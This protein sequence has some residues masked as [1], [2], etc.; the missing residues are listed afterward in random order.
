MFTYS[1]IRCIRR[2]HVIVV[3]WTSKK[4]T[5]KREELL[6][7][8]QN[9]LFFFALSLLTSSYLLK[10][11]LAQSEHLEQYPGIVDRVYRWPAN[12]QGLPPWVQSLWTKS[13]IFPTPWGNKFLTISTNAPGLPW[14]T[15]GRGGGGV[16]QGSRWL[17]QNA[18]NILV[19]TPQFPQFFFLVSYL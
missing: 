5:K 8:S 4:C 9:Q 7:C 6:F 19:A 10:V 2:F 11:P 17:M 3:Q 1:I 13:Y 14:V 18:K 16:G 12:P 15:R